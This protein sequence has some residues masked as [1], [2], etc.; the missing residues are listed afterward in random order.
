MHFKLC[1]I[2]E[3]DNLWFAKIE[4]LHRFMSGNSAPKK[5]QY[6]FTWHYILESEAKI[7]KIYTRYLMLKYSK[8][9]NT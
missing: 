2:L 1:A 6:N 8:K 7:R 9:K 5:R 4:L 3:A